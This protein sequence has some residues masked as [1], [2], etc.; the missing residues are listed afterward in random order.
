MSNMAATKMIDINDALNTLKTAHTNLLS[1]LADIRAGIN[2]IEA[3]VSSLWA[4]PLKLEDFSEVLKKHILNR[5][6]NFAPRFGNVLTNPFRGGLAHN[7]MPWSDFEGDDG[8]SRNLYFND[9]DLFTH[10]IQQGNFGDALCFLFPD[11]VH[12]ALMSRIK[13]TA[14]HKWG[15]EDMPSLADR[16]K[17]LNQLEAKREAMKEQETALN[18]ELNKLNTVHGA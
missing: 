8:S 17:R 6:N 1:Q 9:T 2:N 3:E 14:G 15:N 10:F 16:R 5:G 18:S 11:A 4:M 7:T 12:S 13:E